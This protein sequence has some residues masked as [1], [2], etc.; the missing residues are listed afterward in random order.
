LSAW[1][2][3]PVMSRASRRHAKYAARTIHRNLLNTPSNSYQLYD[4]R[5]AHRG[6]TTQAVQLMV[7]YLFGA[8]KE[9]RIELV[10]VPEMPPR[11]AQLRSVASPRRE[12]PV[13]L[14]LRNAGPAGHA[15]S[16]SG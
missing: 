13:R 7:D 4:D 3:T 11:S 10:I 1:S 6:Y 14:Q 12:P 5:H 8:K 16:A 15:P 9:H 2:A